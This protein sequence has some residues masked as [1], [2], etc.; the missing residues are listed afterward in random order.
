M[1]I[2]CPNCGSP[3][4]VKGNRWECGWC[5]NF[6]GI[7][8]L[9]PSEQ[10]KLLRPPA[11]E[12]LEALERGVFAILEGMRE[13]YGS[14]DAAKDPTWQLAV[15]AVSNA[16]IPASNRT[17]GNLRRL[18]AFFRRY[19]VCTPEEV[20]SAAE[21][22]TPAFDSRFHL[23]GDTLGSFWQELLPRLSSTGDSR[24]LPH[25]LDQIL[26][27]WSETEAFF[28]GADS[29]QRRQELE[30]ALAAHRRSYSLLHPNLT[31]LEDAV[32]RWDFSQYEW[33]CRDLLIAAF[34]ETAGRWSPEEVD[35]MI[36][37]DVLW[38][39]AQQNPDTGIDMMKLLLD[40]AESHLQE[41]EVARELLSW[42]LHDMLMEEP[43]QRRLFQRLPHDE[44]LM[45]QLFSS[46]YAGTPLNDLA[47]ACG[48]LGT[49]ELQTRL[50]ELLERNP[51]Y[52]N[53]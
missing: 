20:L 26:D 4:I 48:R 23:S 47:E 36:T 50:Q 39:A 44:R 34:P 46:A 27:G 21:S 17:E 1:K 33:A 29:A 52:R 51:F 43:V 14:D 10:A 15:H 32:R 22:G 28:T 24:S 35:N 45:G 16:L 19:A 2:R 11:G 53:T 31:A 7:G 40:T 49:P 12:N 9:H 38:E 3:V 8:S 5:G 37:M 18:Q 41:P 25:S 42:D 30:S 13:F 6:G